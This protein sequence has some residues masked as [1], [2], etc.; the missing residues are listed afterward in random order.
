MA[1]VRQ[2][3]TGYEPSAPQHL[4]IVLTSIYH[5]GRLLVS[6]YE[7][8][9]MI[10]AY[11]NPTSWNATAA[12]VGIACIAAWTAGVI[13]SWRKNRIVAW[14][15]LLFGLALAP[16][17]NIVQP[18]IGAPALVAERYLYLPL[19][20]VALLV[21]VGLSAPSSA[22]L[23]TTLAVVVALLC[24]TWI[25]T[26]VVRAADFGSPL[27]FWSAQ[28]AVD[29][30][31][32]LAHQKLAYE[33]LR[34]GRLQ[35]A[36]QQMVA[37]LRNWVRVG[38][39]SGLLTLQLRF[40]EARASATPASQRAYLQRAER[41]LSRLISIAGQPRDPARRVDLAFGA[42]QLSIACT[43]DAL[44]ELR[45]SLP[46]LRRLHAMLRRRAKTK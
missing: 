46:R 36:E 5:Y 3:P 13:L 33:H 15:L 7:P 42:M 35:R 27:R 45:A 1:A 43:A 2:A 32:P 9:A 29:A 26:V 30:D 4:N 37:A 34:A 16:T 14:A 6:P 17:L 40:I 39:R 28:L 11:F 22:R 23:R 38:R 12:I 25:A 31:N 24:C 18:A 21:V 8:N 19:L 10:G 44:A 41:Q 20:G